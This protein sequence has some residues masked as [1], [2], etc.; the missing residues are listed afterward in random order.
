MSDPPGGAVT[1]ERLLAS[2]Q[3][4][5]WLPQLL[6]TLYDGQDPGTAAGWARRIADSLGQAPFEVVHDWQARTVVPL[7]LRACEPA[8][9]EQV[10]DQPSPDEAAGADLQRM[11][12]RAAAGERFGEADWRAA[13]EPA[14]RTLY[15][16]AYGYAEAYAT[17]RASAIAYAHANDFSESGAIQ[18]ADSYAKMST[19]SNRKSY[20][21]SNAVA[22]AAVL[23]AAYA[24]GD[25][26]AY[27][28]SYPFALVH[29]CAHACA[30]QA[31]QAGDEATTQVER[32]Q[33]AYTRLAEGLADSL[34]RFR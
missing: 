7:I 13:I 14:L 33:A 10:T 2:G 20:A 3:L 23:A 31:D 21:E 28:D 4:P 18:F 22:N 1:F 25:A 19:D 11:H 32:R 8:V 27:A 24:S 16:Q 30:N 12:A 26:Q 6:M 5:A 34:A 17:A 15:Q 9:P 29:A